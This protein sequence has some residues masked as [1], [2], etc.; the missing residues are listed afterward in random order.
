MAGTFH[1]LTP[2]DAWGPLHLEVGLVALAPLTPVVAS[3]TRDGAADALVEARHR[4]SDPGSGT[5]VHLMWV[6]IDQ[7]RDVAEESIHA[8]IT[9]MSIVNDERVNEAPSSPRYH[10][11]ARELERL[12]ALVC[13]ATNEAERRAE[14]EALRQQRARSGD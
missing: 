7:V 2:Q 6:P 8:L 13:V 1:P 5:G 12:A 14:D 9:R 4:W 3:D 10:R 11:A